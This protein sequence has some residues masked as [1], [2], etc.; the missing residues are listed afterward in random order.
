MNEINTQK[1]YFA[2]SDIHGFYDEMVSALRHAGYSKKDKGHILIVIGDLFDRGSGAV[3][4]YKYLKSIPQ[5]RLILL[6]GNHEELY[7]ELL[8]KDYPQRHDFSNMTVDTF[9]QIAGKE[10]LEGKEHIKT[11]VWLEQFLYKPNYDAPTTKDNEF[12]NTE[13][14]HKLWIEIRDIVR[15]HEITKWLKKP[16]WKEYYELGDYIFTHSFIPT[17]P[18]DDHNWKKYPSYDENFLEVVPNWRTEA[19]E[20]QWASAHWGCPWKQYKLGLF[21]EEETNGKILVCGHWH[22][23]DFFEHL[24]N[25]A[26]LRDNQSI[27]RGKNIIAIDGGVFGH[28]AWYGYVLSHPQNVLV[29]R[30]RLCCDAFGF[31]LENMEKEASE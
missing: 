11:A 10:Y 25:Y 18:I 17:R 31:E 7:F 26:D 5:S 9:C 27:F 29:I 24:G 23:S 16:I 15:E 13:E 3:K 6:K 20:K 1:T 19:T 12:D 28:W 4:T 2:I 30:G 22:T 8:D 21:K 14:A